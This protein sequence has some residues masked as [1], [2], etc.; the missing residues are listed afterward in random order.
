MKSWLNNPI[1]NTL[2]YIYTQIIS[3]KYKLPLF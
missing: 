3:I 1:N 2:L